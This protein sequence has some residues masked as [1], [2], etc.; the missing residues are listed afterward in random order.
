MDAPT[1]RSLSSQSVH[2]LVRNPNHDQLTLQ[3]RQPNIPQAILRQ[4]APNRPPQNLPT[5]IPLH[6]PLHTDLLQTTRPR[7]VPV[8]LMLLHLLARDMQTLAVGGY[9]VIAAVCGRV[10]DGFVLAHEDDGEAGGEAAEGDRRVG[11]GDV[12]PRA[13]VGQAGLQRH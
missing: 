9:D 7:R 3:P 1:L 4:H 13:G 6:Q 11:E 12:V 8:I 10:V 5:S 2:H